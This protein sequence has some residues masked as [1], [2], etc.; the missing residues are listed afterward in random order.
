[1]CGWNCLKR[2]PLLGKKFSGFM[3]SALLTWPSIS[4]TNCSIFSI[5]LILLLLVGVLQIT[6]NASVT[7]LAF[8]TLKVV[9]FPRPFKANVLL[10]HVVAWKAHGFT[11][12]FTKSSKYIVRWN[13]IKMLSRTKG[14]P[15]LFCIDLFKEWYSKCDCIII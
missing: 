11:N 5:A 6:W 12:I 13:L 2:P 14:N 4:L 15:E 8:Q 7:S 3:F 9:L 10:Y 1:M